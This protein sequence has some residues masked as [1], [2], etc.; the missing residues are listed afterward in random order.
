MLTLQ[1][2]LSIYTLSGMAQFCPI[3]EPDTA[4]NLQ[5]WPSAPSDFL[6]SSKG[7]SSGKAQPTRQLEPAGHRGACPRQEVSPQTLG[8]W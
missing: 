7:D 4:L 5:G 8:A 3:T 2:A 6:L 1:L